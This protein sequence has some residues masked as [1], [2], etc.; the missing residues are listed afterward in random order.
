[1]AKMLWSEFVPFWREISSAC[2]GQISGSE[3]T[4]QISTSILFWL[5]AF[6]MLHLVLNTAIYGTGSKK[7][8]KKY[9]GSLDL[10]K[11]ELSRYYL[12]P[13][14]KAAITA[15]FKEEGDNATA[16]MWKNIHTARIA[17]GYLANN[18]NPKGVF[19]Y[20]CIAFSCFNKYCSV[21]KCLFKRWIRGV[22]EDEVDWNELDLFEHDP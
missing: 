13:D 11:G 2:E 18:N 3:V 7:S 16:E 21:T 17:D 15:H 10:H 4:A 1:M 8:D 6:P 14:R 12:N 20:Y 19:R 22:E 9:G 5:L